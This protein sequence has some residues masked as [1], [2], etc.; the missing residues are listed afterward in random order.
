MAQFRATPGTTYVNKGT[1]ENIS[2]T[3]EQLA[4]PAQGQ[5][6]G[7]QFSE[8][9]TGNFN[10]LMGGQDSNP[11]SAGT[12]GIR[13]D[14]T[15]Q[16]NNF[17]Q[18]M[19]NVEKSTQSGD[20]VMEELT[21]QLD[22]L[23]QFST[24]DAL[25]IQS[26]GI[27]AGEAYQP[28][29][30]AAEQSRKTA[31]P[32]D[33]VRAGEAGGFLNTQQAG[34]AALL[35]TDPNRGEAFVGAGGQ[36]DL[37]RQKLDLAVQGA[38]SAQRRAIEEAKAAE[39]VAIASGKKEHFQMAFKLADLA[40]D[41][42][43]QAEKL[44]IDR[45]NLAL[46]VASEQRLQTGAEFDIRREIPQGESITIGGS[47]FTG[48]EIPEAEKDFFS[49]SNLIS[50]MK[51]MPRGETTEVT[52]P[53][54]GRVFTL[55]GLEDA[56]TITA[57]DDQGNVSIIDKNTGE[58]LNKVEGVGK[59]KAAPISITLRQ[60]MGQLVGNISDSLEKERGADGKVNPAEYQKQQDLYIRSGAGNSSDFKNLFPPEENLSKDNPDSVKFFQAPKDVLKGDDPLSGANLNNAIANA[61][62]E[63]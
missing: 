15:L 10:D 42:K 47:I 22:E 18:F 6:S 26:A 2:F 53:N 8:R 48:L 61:L 43:Q 62:K 21:R 29:V 5:L 30:A 56:S 3:E 4:D 52:D 33:V 28:Q 32:A 25:R 31:L 19:S 36:L 50:L 35:P 24:D 45:A 17:N 46:N 63:E 41:F 14:I 55:T 58:V 1:G 23:G 9:E 16:D 11:I 27:S 38:K 20:S 37:S 59:T 60:E 44:Q 34:V 51:S 57:T 7:D 40:N 49:G 12:E 54:T 39:R 13:E